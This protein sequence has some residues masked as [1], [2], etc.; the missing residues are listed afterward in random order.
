M[1]LFI[2]EDKLAPTD[3]KEADTCSIALPT[4][5]P[6]KPPKAR[7][8]SCNAT[9]PSPTIHLNP[10]ICAIPPSAAIIAT[11]SATN[12]PKPANPAIADGIKGNKAAHIPQNTANILAPIVIWTMVFQSKAATASNILVNSTFIKSTAATTISGMNFVNAFMAFIIIRL[13]L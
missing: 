13:R 1:A 5:L 3:G 4:K 9:P 7:P 10:G 12:N 6:K 2:N 11:A 8:I